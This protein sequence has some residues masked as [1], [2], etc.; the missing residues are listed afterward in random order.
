MDNLDIR[1]SEVKDLDD[2]LKWLSNPEIN[3]WL[4]MS[5]KKEIEASASNCIGFSKYKSSLT[6]VVDNKVCAIGT[7]FLMPYKKLAHHAMFYLI[8]DKKYQRK[9]VGSDMLKN[10][11]NLAQ[12][13][14]KLESIYVEVFEDCPLIS[15]LRKFNFERLAYQEKFV[16]DKNNKYLARV[17]YDLWLK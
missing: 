15:L 6:G 17:L 16:K 9:G 7:L 10:L 1:Y 5:K 3:N 12:N 14:F 13:H 2:L 11:I 8:V 4:L